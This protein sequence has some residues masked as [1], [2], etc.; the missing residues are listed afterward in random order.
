MFYNQQYREVTTLGWWMIV[1]TVVALVAVI[2]LSF[3]YVD[4]NSPPRPLA[5]PMQYTSY[6]ECR[7]DTITWTADETIRL[8]HADQERRNDDEL[9]PMTEETQDL[10]IVGY[11]WR[12]HGIVTGYQTESRMKSVRCNPL[13]IRQ[14]DTIGEE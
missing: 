4:R 2:A 5:P 1:E 8:V 6:V 11:E 7:Y 3:Y 9:T 10:P 12:Y 14:I 13:E